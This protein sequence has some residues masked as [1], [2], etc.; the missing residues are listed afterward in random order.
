MQL[1]VK[2]STNSTTTGM[3]VMLSFQMF[4]LS[5]GELTSL[6]FFVAFMK[7]LFFPLHLDEVFLFVC[8][9]YTLYLD[10]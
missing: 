9:R 4:G 10:N 2:R 3:S 7:F 8:L 5:L 6:I 1:F